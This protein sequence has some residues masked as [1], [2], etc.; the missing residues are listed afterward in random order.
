M[1]LD[2]LS[3]LENMVIIDFL[4]FNVFKKT[5]IL[6]NAF[7]GTPGKTILGKNNVVKINFSPEKFEY[8]KIICPK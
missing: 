3:Y 6:G 5:L 7:Y 2:A 8:K 1:Y 4:T